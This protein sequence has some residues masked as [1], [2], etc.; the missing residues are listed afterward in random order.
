MKRKGLTFLI[1][2]F[3]IL[4]IC[5]SHSQVSK[6]QVVGIGQN[7]NSPYDEQAPILSPDGQKLYFTRSKHPENSGG[8]KDPGDIWM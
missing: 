2:P 4:I 8:T 7:V 6:Y 3:F 5:N 1:V